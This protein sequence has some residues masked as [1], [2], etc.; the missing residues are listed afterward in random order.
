MY[1]LRSVLAD[2]FGAN[3]VPVRILLAEFLG[4][5]FLVA[6]GD[7]SV[8]QMVLSKGA[9]NSFFTVTIAY[10]LAVAFGVYLAIG[11]SGKKIRIC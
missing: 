4:T 10:G 5:A 9:L 8:A 6:L 2:Y 11:V 1:D 7:G 3:L